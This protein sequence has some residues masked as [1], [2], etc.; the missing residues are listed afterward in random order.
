ML[1]FIF[2]KQNSRQSIQQ[3][4]ISNTPLLSPS[5]SIP[6]L[7]TSSNE[8]PPLYPKVQW[9]KPYPTKMRIKLG[10]VNSSGEP[11]FLDLDALE[12]DSIILPVNDPYGEDMLGYYEQE[13]LSKGWVD[14]MPGAAGG[15]SGQHQEW[16]KN[17][18]YF[19][20]GYTAKLKN[21]SV[22]GYQYTIIHN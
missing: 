11:N 4:P 10:T 12:T 5:T 15:P 6:T 14:Y 8:Y 7:S 13:L 16:I 1:Y 3:P 19:G 9:G 21:G 22:I 2:Q 18:N 20:A 17:K